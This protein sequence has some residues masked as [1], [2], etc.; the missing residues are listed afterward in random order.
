[1]SRPKDA[2]LLRVL[3]KT[4][5]VASLLEE[6]P[7]VPRG[8]LRRILEE[9]AR[10]LDETSGEVFLYTDGASRGNP[11]PAGAGA[12]LLDG[13]GKVL[14]ESSEYLG[15]A[16]N[17]EAEYRALLLGLSLARLKGV[18]RLRLRSDS[19]L[20]A[21]QLMG[22]YRVRHPRLQV[23]FEAAKGLIGSFEA[24]HIERVLRE[25]N[26][27]ADVLANQAIE[28]GLREGAP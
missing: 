25:E 22:R 10:R 15:E 3:A 2:D 1:M 8:D 7:E 16:T 14:G 9:A 26:A 28:E 23:L 11:G 13:R 4:L 24:F 5:D 21:R 27:K 19:E 12:V 17:N 20:L 18:K 6:H